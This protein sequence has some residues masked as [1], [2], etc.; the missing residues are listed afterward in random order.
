MEMENMDKPTY[1][2]VN[3][4]ILDFMT[5]TGPL[6]YIILG[7]MFT[8]AILLFFAPWTYQIYV[9]QG[10]TGL[11]IPVFWGVY[12]VNFVFWVGIA[13]AGTL[14]SAMLFITKTPWRRAI[15][16]KKRNDIRSWIIAVRITRCGMAKRLPAH[17]RAL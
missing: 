11:N 4:D 1:R 6:Y 16:R 5:K 13:H 15:A 14:I 10:V 17:F 3:K 12:L 8:A 2:D 7:C 9:G